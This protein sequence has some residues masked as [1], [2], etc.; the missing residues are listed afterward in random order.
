M[1]EQE[2]RYRTI[3]F[4]HFLCFLLSRLE[5]FADFDFDFVCIGGKL[6]AQALFHYFNAL[7]RVPLVQSGFDFQEIFVDGFENSW[8]QGLEDFFCSLKNACKYLEKSAEIAYVLVVGLTRSCRFGW[9]FDFLV[10]GHRVGF[11]LL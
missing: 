8:D 3:F 4:R 9:G 10:R 6:L 11:G 1:I 7:D 2:S 5:I